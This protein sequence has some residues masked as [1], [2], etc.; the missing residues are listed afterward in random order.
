LPCSKRNAERFPEDF[1][2]QLTAEEDAALR[3]QIATSN[4]AGRGGRR[5]APYAFT[6]HGAIQAANVLNSPRA[7]EMSLYVVRAFVQLREVLASNKGLAHKLAALERSLVTLD[8][9]TQRRFQ[10]VYEA[11]RALMSDPAPKRRGIGFTADL[12]DKT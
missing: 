1:M 11:I 5:Y 12:D 2:F 10:E 3:S 6:D 4:G 7:V 8:L 9:K